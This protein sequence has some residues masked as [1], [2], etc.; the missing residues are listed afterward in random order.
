MTL[1][2]WLIFNFQ[3]PM[4]YYFVEFFS[5]YITLWIIIIFQKSVILPNAKSNV[6]LNILIY[7]LFFFLILFYY[8]FSYYNTSTNWFLKFI[9]KLTLFK[10][11]EDE[12]IIIVSRIIR[13]Q[14]PD[15]I[16]TAGPELI[17]E[18]F[19]SIC[20][21]NNCISNIAGSGRKSSGP[22]HPYEKVCIFC[23]PIIIKSLYLT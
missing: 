5:H 15:L 14:T 10:S 4:P 3:Y 19:D 2:L 23:Y 8:T 9:L 12:V 18:P 1:K 20:Q 13:P 11:A 17:I 22:W 6:T 7:W 21:T 16:R